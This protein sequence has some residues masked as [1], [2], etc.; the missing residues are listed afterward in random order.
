MG[1]FEFDFSRDRAITGGMA[2]K[3]FIESK[4]INGVQVTFQWQDGKKYAVAECPHCGHRESSVDHGIDCGFITVGKLKPHI[5]K[6]P[7]REGVGS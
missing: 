5:D 2:K 7:C 6:C 3:T 4:I 1:Y